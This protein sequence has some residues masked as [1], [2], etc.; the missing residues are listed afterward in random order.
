MRSCCDFTTYR[1]SP[2][3]FLAKIDAGSGA[4]DTTFRQSTGVVRRPTFGPI[5]DLEAVSH[6]EAMVQSALG[7]TSVTTFQGGQMK[8]LLFAV[9]ALSITACA[10]LEPKTISSS[11]LPLQKQLIFKAGVDETFA[12]TKQVFAD[13]GWKLLYEGAEPPKREYAYFSNRGP[14]DGSYDRLAWGKSTAGPQPPRKYL[15]AKTPTSAFSFGAELFV[16]LFEGPDGGSA[17]A[18]T[19]STSQ[20]NEKDKLESY[21]G[22]FTTLLTQKVK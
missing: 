20:M 22:E 2:V 10:N 1:G 11:E 17:V 18:I 19:A 6:F 4:L 5:E 8:H 15:E 13:K 9:L 3:N 7:H 21:I 12:A 14:F 16:A